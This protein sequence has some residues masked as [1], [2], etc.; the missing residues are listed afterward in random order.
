MCT[1]LANRKDQRTA[2]IITANAPHTITGVQWC[3]CEATKTGVRSTGHCP[4][5]DVR[6]CHAVVPRLNT[7]EWYCSVLSSRVS[8]V[9]GADH[10][11]VD[12]CDRFGV[13][14]GRCAI[15]PCCCA[16]PEHFRMVLQCAQL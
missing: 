2:Y 5:R 15:V 1:A 10:W 6:L 13:P 7:S 14:E 3:T 8:R 11:H 16:T 4:P 12:V 9:S